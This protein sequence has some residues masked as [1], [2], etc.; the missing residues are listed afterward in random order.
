MPQYIEKLPIIGYAQQMIRTVAV[1]VMDDVAMFE[2]GVACEVFGTDRGAD[3]FPT[4]EFQV[5]SPDGATVRSTSGFGVVPHAD[6]DPIASADLV[7]VPPHSSD[8]PT[9]PAVLSALRAAH[10]NGARLL[11]ICTG[12]FALGE[13]GLLDGRRCTTHWH[14]ADKLAARFPAAIVDPSVLYVSDGNLLTSAGTAA[15]IDACLYLVREVHGSAVA[16]KLARRMVVPPHRAGGQSQYVE[17]PMPEPDGGGSLEPLL[18]WLV[19]NLD[20]QVTIDDLA[21]RVHM[22]SRT[23][24]RRFK[25]ETGATPHD[26]LT[27]QRVL[28]ARRLLEDTSLG[29]DAVAAHAGFGDAVNLR[30]HFTRR[31]GATPQSYRLTFRTAP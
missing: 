16:T 12:A 19:A 8:V 20:Q 11:S 21:A 5:C 22:A 9:P 6:L 24:A 2:L 7:I 18:A 27:G 14:H 25:A 23:F 3:G 17:T 10:A 26:W 29:V 28:L 4:Y 15:G 31:V 1:L 30:H 13:A